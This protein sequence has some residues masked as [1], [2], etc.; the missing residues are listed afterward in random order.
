PTRVE[1]GMGLCWSCVD[2]CGPGVGV[3]AAEKRDVQKAW[4]I[5]V[6]HVA[7]PA[8]EE[9]PVLETRDSRADHE[10]WRGRDAPSNTSPSG[11]A[12]RTRALEFL[13]IWLAAA[14]YTS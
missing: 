14:A 8:G 11:W 9:A 3:G 13:R 1:A 5:E 2:P 10:H 6:G 4:T 7:G 12:L